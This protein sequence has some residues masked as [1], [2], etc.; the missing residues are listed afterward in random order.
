MN[1]R[2][3]SLASVVIAVATL[4]GACASQSGEAGRAALGALEPPST[5]T[6]TRPATTTTTDPNCND[7]NARDSLPASEL[8]PLDQMPPDSVMAAIQ[9]R[10]HLIV[11]IDEN[12]PRLAARDR[13]GE[14]RG[15]EVDLVRAIA[16]AI[17]GSPDNVVFKTVVTAEKNQVVADGT[18]DLTA[19][20]DSIN[21][22]RKALVDFSEEYYQA[23]HKLLVRSDSDI[24]GVADLAG[25]TVCVTAGSSSV[26][27]LQE[28]A[29][30]AKALEVPARTDCLLALQQ[31]EA[32]AY[33]GHDIFLRGMKDQ[34]PL[35]RILP[36]SLK[37]Q[38]YGIA[39]SQEHPELVQFVNAV[40]E[41]MRADGT[42]DRLT[43]CWLRED[44]PAVPASGCGT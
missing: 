32:D 37:D 30:R 39:I 31:G 42:M 40:L 21:C 4:A 8:Y 6:T 38:H 9:Q 13:N 27:L 15:F 26:K 7:Q 29:P 14:I 34:D 20:A 11:G 23:E 12:T 41:R 36:D 3:A 35:T 18:V 28:Q 22:E 5:T 33:L 1:R 16:A 19:S 17:T 24:Q 43:H 25:H 2:A 44:A 10:G